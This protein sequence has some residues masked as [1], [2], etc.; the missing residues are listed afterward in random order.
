MTHAK[1]AVVHV[2]VGDRVP[3]SKVKSVFE[4]GYLPNWTEEE[5]FVHSINTKYSPT[6]FKLRDYSGEVIEGSFYRH[7]IQPILRDDNMFVVER[8]LKRRRRHGVL[9][10][11]VKWRGYP[12]SMNSWVED[13]RRL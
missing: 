3:I 11:F 8:I 5:F 9:Q 6:M 4:K 7:E 13:V 10:Y 1:R 12:S 2:S